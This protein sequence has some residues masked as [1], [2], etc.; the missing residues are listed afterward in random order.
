LVLA[1]EDCG[2]TARQAKKAVAAVW[3][4]MRSGLKAEGF[5]E[6]SLGIL[7]VVRR[8]TQ[9]SRRFGRKLLVNQQ[10]RI[11]FKPEKSLVR[12]INPEV[13]EDPVPAKQYPKNQ[14][15]CDICGSVEFS[16]AQFKQYLPLSSS[17]PGD[18][19]H[20]VSING[21][22]VPICMCGNPI[23]PCQLR[24]T[25]VSKS[26]RESFGKSF[27]AARQWR[28]SV[29]PASIVAQLS[30]QS[31]VAKTDY[32]RLVEKV[33]KLAAIVREMPLPVKSI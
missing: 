22:R 7:R 2:L 3:N 18:D 30:V 17:L 13:K 1:V 24:L 31:F 16:E 15:I 20:P 4:A 14:L 29:R 8:P 25:S 5:V 27:E 6:T 10:A 23:L 12:S 11:V 33:N 9:Q 32:D 19:F 26:D 21:I 28:Q